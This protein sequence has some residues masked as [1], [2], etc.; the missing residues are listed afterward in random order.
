M[1]L[2]EWDDNFSIDKSAAPKGSVSDQRTRNGRPRRDSTFG[3]DSQISPS[4]ISEEDA[5]LLKPV[6]DTCFNK[7]HT[8]SRLLKLIRAQINNDSTNH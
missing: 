4:I 5:Q 7:R 8:L 1:E 6:S 3:S 2:R